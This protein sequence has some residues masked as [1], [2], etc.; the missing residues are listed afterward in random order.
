MGK[1]PALGSDAIGASS[2][3]LGV[4]TY[5]IVYSGAPQI[6]TGGVPLVLAV[7]FS[8]VLFGGVFAAVFG[9]RALGTLIKPA[10]RT[11]LRQRH[12]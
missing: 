1:L 12:L 6:S 4:L 11:L 7:A 10:P 3:F 9:P 2:L 8:I 5:Q